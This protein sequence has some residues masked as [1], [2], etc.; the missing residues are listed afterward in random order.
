MVND[1]VDTK[2]MHAL[3]SEEESALERNNQT[4]HGLKILSPD[5]M[6]SRLPVTLP[7]LQAG[8]NS[9]KLKNKIK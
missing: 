1:N 8:K 7:Q 3:E 5:Q 9:Q 2:Y 6:L 4:R